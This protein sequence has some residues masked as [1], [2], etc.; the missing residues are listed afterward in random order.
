M[1]RTIPG[2]TGTV[3]QPEETEYQVG[4]PALPAAPP[5]PQ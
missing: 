3:Q 1:K 2:T 4:G 5:R